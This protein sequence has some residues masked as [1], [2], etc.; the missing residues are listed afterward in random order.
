VDNVTTPTPDIAVAPTPAPAAVADLLRTADLPADDLGRHEPTTVWTARIAGE[1][2][3]TASL[4]RHECYGLL[5]SVVVAEPYRGHGWARRL[6]E[7]ALSAARK[8]DL[9]A[10][11][12]LTET[13]ADYFFGLGFVAIGRRA[14]PP[15]VRQ[16]TEFAELCPD[17]A[18]AMVRELH[19]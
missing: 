13:A 15:V 18:V 17:S 16:S 1:I 3:G 12:L 6:T 4:E 2:Q 9:V 7:A 11:Y 10:V 5:R 14:V 19:V 8:A